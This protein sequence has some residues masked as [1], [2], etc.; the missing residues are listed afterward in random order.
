[1]RKSFLLS[2]LTVAALAAA[3]LGWQVWQPQPV[4]RPSPMASVFEASDAYQFDPPAPG[5]Y[6]LNRIKSAPDGRVLDI[7]GREHSLHDLTRGKISLVSFVYLTCGDVNGCPLAMSVFFD[8]HDA[9]RDL[10]GL[11]EDVQ[12]LTIS[13]DP[14]RD[15]VEAIEAFAYPITSDEQA[16]DK[17]DWHVLTTSGSPALTP[18]L[19]GY[20]QV[21]DRSEDQET[22]SHLLRL[23]LVDRQGDIRNVY[24]LGFL[25]PRL[26]LTDIETLL[27]EEAGA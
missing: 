7:A 14:A 10:P 22:I 5:S 19:D 16:G 27:M 23:Y 2:G 25:D 11:N 26:L 21:V 6:R 24:G 17:L 4:A 20:G 13:F 1:M 18:I 8:V 3:A 15:T 12:L 9:S